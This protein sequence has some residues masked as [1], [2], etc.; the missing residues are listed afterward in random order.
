MLIYKKYLFV[1]AFVIN[2]LLILMPAHLAY[3]AIFPHRRVARTER[4]LRRYLAF[5]YRCLADR[6][7]WQMQ[8]NKQLVPK[9]L[10]C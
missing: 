1:L 8:G 5:R 3:L 6:S 10:A 2:E 4:W 9:W 7:V